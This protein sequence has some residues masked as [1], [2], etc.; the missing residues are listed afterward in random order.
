M[1]QQN[2]EGLLQACKDFKSYQV[3][4]QSHLHQSHAESPQTG[5]S[6]FLIQVTLCAACKLTTL[7]VHRKIYQLLEGEFRAGLH[8]LSI[9]M[10]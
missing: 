7:Q 1:R 10:M 4:N 5:Q 6:H 2:I 9:E 8:A 3:I